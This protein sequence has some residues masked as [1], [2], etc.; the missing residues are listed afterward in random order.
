MA[1]AVTIGLAYGISAYDACYVALS[2]QVK[3]TLLTQD[4]RLVN[5]LG[6]A[7]YDVCLFTDFA[8]PP[9]PLT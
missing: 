6:S 9:A 4:Q 2:Q 3:A 5:A 8:L 1:D 7:A